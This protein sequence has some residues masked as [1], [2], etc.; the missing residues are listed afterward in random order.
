[1]H[2]GVTLRVPAE[3][4]DLESVGARLPLAHD[5]GWAVDDVLGRDVEHVIVH[6]EAARP[7]EHRVDLLDLAVGVPEAD[8]AA[9]VHRVVAHTDALGP[10]GVAQEARLA[11]LPHAE[12]R[13]DVLRGLEIGGRVRGAHAA[14]PSAQ[15]PYLSAVTCLW[16]VF[17][18]R[19]EASSCSRSAPW[20]SWESGS[21]SP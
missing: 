3:G 19:T 7:R 8:P 1:M 17:F 5:A 11:H 9:G 13:G 16:R 14:A 4:D 20:R 2:L 21:T 18:A 15:L 6:L 10:Q 12:P